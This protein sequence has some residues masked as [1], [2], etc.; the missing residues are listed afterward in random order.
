M[1]PE[2]A[3]TEV[4]ECEPEDAPELPSNV[5]PPGGLAITVA[6]RNA[7]KRAV[8][9]AGYATIKLDRIEAKSEL[10]KYLV[11][12]GLFRLTATQFIVT[13]EQLEEAI[14]TTVKLDAELTDPEARA[15]LIQTREKLLKQRVDLIGI[16]F[17]AGAEGMQSQTQ[18][19]PNNVPFPCNTPITF[20][21]T[22][23]AQSAEVKS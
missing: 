10:G 19:N 1:K 15:T 5:S 8:K 16:G 22:A 12:L 9:K 18:N 13:A 2:T 6:E 7:A 17:K 21:V 3:L 23:T 4:V 20:N 11:A 14:E